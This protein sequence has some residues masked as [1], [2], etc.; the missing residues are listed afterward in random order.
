[1]PLTMSPFGIFYLERLS[2]FAG[3]ITIRKF[4]IGNLSVAKFRHSII[5][6][7]SILMT[8]TIKNAGVNHDSKKQKGS[9]KRA[10]QMLLV[11]RAG[12]EPAR[13]SA[14]DFESRASTYSAI[15]A[16]HGKNYDR[17]RVFLQ[18]PIPNCWYILRLRL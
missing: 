3:T 11:P 16:T 1:M 2:S 13:L 7:N 6:E 14:R 4:G 9:P 12:I 8:G 5:F 15:S 17:V 10:L 18:A